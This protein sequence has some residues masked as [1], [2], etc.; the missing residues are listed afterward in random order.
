MEQTNKLVKSIVKGI[1]EK[2]GTD[3]VVADLRGIDGT[4]CSR[5]HDIYGHPNEIWWKV[6][7]TVIVFRL[8]P[9]MTDTLIL[10]Q[11]VCFLMLSPLSSRS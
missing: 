8:K 11:R 1:Q 10:A 4:I 6:E 9:I 7:S 2:K 3:I 5:Y